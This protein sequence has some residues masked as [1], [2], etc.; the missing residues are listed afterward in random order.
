MGRADDAVA[1]F[2]QI[3][4]IHQRQRPAIVGTGIDIAGHLV[5]LSDDE[6]GKE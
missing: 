3:A 5:A 6:S 2:G 1:I 4:V